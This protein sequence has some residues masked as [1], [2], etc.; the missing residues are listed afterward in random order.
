MDLHYHLMLF[1]RDL[2]SWTLDI[3]SERR[4]TDHTLLERGSGNSCSV[5]FNTLYRLH[6]AMSQDDE[7]FTGRACF[8]S[9]HYSPL[10]QQMLPKYRG[11]I[12][13]AFRHR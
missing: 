2:S 5:E 10:I 13:M 3:A 7:K 6:P 1:C 4:E 11:A 12:Q 8:L 9:N